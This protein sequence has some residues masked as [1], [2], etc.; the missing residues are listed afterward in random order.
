[1]VFKEQTIMSSIHSTQE[2]HIAYFACIS[3]F[4]AYILTLHC[5]VCRYV[6]YLYIWLYI[7]V[8]FPYVSYIYVQHMT[9]NRSCLLLQVM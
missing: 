4:S 5:S 6:T 1:M 2:S 3:A 9:C 7:C 8:T